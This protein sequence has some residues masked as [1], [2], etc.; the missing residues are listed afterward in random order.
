VNVVKFPSKLPTPGQLELPRAQLVGVLQELSTTLLTQAN[1]LFKAATAPEFAAVVRDT[2]A[3]V[4]DA[5]AGWAAMS[6]AT[7]SWKG[8]RQ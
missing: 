3:K 7:E 4:A 2:A 6:A 1:E 8:S 5:N